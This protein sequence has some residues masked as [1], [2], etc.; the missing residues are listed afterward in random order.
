M[1]AY[2]RKMFIPVEFQTS[3]WLGFCLDN[4]PI[5]VNGVANISTLPIYLL[6]Y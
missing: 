5:G 3:G 4:F 1:L 2:H 6:G